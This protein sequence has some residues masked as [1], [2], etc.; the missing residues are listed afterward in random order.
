[1]H[2]TPT[3]VGAIA[4][5][6]SSLSRARLFRYTKDESNCV[7][8][9]ADGCVGVVLKGDIQIESMVAQGAKP[10]GGVYQIVKGQESTINSIA[11]DEA[12]TEIVH[13]DEESA[14]DDHDNNDE[15]EGVQDTKA[16]MAKAYAKARIP[17]PVLAEANFLMKNLGDDERAFMSKILLVGLERKGGRNPSDL[18]RLAEGKGPGFTVHQVASA[19][20]KD[21]SV[22]LS[23]GSVD[24]KAG[25]RLRFYVREASYAKKELWALWAGYQHR[26]K[27]GQIPRKSSNIFSPAG[28]LIFPTLDRG[29]KF[30]MGK[31]G[32]ESS[33][34][35]ELLPTIPSVSGFYGNGVIGRLD[36]DP[37]SGGRESS[38]LSGSASGYVLVGSSK[39]SVRD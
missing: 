30:F 36:S 3:I 29:N 25:Q 4:S 11:L 20:T 22:T 5:T 6:V 24:I 2:V 1:M 9:L 26:L 7:Q 14:D 15:S 37:D 13:Q 19:G 12:A 21:G 31:S 27:G 39:Y 23:L 34:V 28:C 18:I 17:K 10:V 8:T 32:F 38:S 16:Q 35:T 33:T